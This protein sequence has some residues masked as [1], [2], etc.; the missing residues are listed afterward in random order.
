MG[1]YAKFWTAAVGA[2]T[3]AASLA[4]GGFT[5]AEGIAIAL[6]ALSAAG[7]YAVPNTDTGAT[8]AAAARPAPRPS[9]VRRNPA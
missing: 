3:V 4:P 6:A 8:L 5:V 1:R 7:V 9:T 2:L